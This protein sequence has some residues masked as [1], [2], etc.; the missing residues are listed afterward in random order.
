L[1][2]A[3][4]GSRSRTVTGWELWRL[5]PALRWYVCGLVAAALVVGGW[6]AARI[7]WRLHDA[8]L[9]G[10]LTCFGAL[11]L[12][13]GRRTAPR[14]PAGL[15]KD[16]L[17]VWLLPTAFL[18]PPVYGLAAPVLTFTLLQARTRRTI[19]HRRVFSAAAHGLT[20]AAVS[21]GFHALP[22]TP[23]RPALWLLATIGC[24]AARLV[25]ITALMGTAGWLADR[26]VS[27]RDAL[28]TPPALANDVADLA[29]GVLIA[30]GM[31]GFGPLLLIPALPLVVILQH[32]FRRA[33]LDTRADAETGL[34]N[35]T[36]WRAEAEVQLARA[37]R[38]GSP[39]AVG[40]VALRDTHAEGGTG[41][42]PA[43]D[44][45]LAA[46]TTIRSG[47]RPYDLTGQLTGEEIIF[48]LPATT[49]SEA[50]QIAERL[51]GSLA[52]LPVAYTAD[53]PSVA[54]GIAAALK[55]AVADLAELLA[56]ADAALFRAKQTGQDHVCLTPLTPDDP[57]P[58][59]SAPDDHD[60]Q[61]GIEAAWQALGQQL[62]VAR[63]RAGLTQMQLAHRTPYARSTIAN[64][65]RGKYSGKPAFW[66]ACDVATG[67]EGAI[68]A[69]HARIIALIAA[70]H[71]RAAWETS[72]ARTE[73]DEL[74]TVG[75]TIPDAA[76]PLCPNCGTSLVG[77]Q[78]PVTGQITV[79][80]AVTRHH[81]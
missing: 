9:F 78:L 5:P 21:A 65:E 76:V 3:N 26:T 60:D 4:G 14:E 67:A 15:I 43:R 41:R 40:I 77:L 63:E 54:I 57:G 37:Q 11:A 62:R 50:Q 35:P 46:T 80:G 19:A 27:I 29:V 75:G 64:A 33:Q 24:A 32:S 39:L 52:K 23:A 36:A 8:V 69:G 6:T 7:S 16:P 61:E 72:Q 34:L 70:A 51:R 28:L 74:V 59:T 13:L 1:N 12:E 2:V 30:A 42:H 25:V 66:V 31:P 58:D 45:M 68:K 20:L 71:N 22:V 38:T 18:L 44:A 10:L 53:H 49:A 81:S 79:L 73:A 55:P 48:L 47:L 56:A 17:A